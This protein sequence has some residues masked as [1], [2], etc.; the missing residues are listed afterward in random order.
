MEKYFKYIVIGLLLVLILMRFFETPKGISES[1]MTYRLK[2]HDLNQ[3]KLELLKENNKLESK[4]NYFQDEII[5]NNN[6]IDSFT[7]VQLDSSF[8]AYFNR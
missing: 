1:E 6:A 7:I 8:A 4:L 3:D 2:V 5:K